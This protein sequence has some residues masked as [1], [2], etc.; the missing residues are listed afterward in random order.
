MID[1]ELDVST[2]DAQVTVRRTH[3]TTLDIEFHGNQRRSSYRTMPNRTRINKAAYAVACN[4]R[5]WK[6]C[7]LLAS[8]AASQHPVQY[9]ASLQARNAI[10]ALISDSKPK[11]EGP[12]R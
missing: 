7:P 5:L 9:A 11:Q 12:T 2:C 10:E 8:L 1:H 6:R 4:W 3:G